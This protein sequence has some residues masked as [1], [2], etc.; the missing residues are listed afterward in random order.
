MWE[1]V[2]PAANLVHS[3]RSGWAAARGGASARH[4]E[5]LGTVGAAQPRRPCSSASLPPT[6]PS[7]H[8]PPTPVPALPYPWATLPRATRASAAALSALRR[9]LSS[10]SLP[11]RALA[12]LSDLAGTPVTLSSEAAGPSLH[13][14]VASET[15]TLRLTGPASATALTPWWVVLEVD[16]ALAVALVARVTKRPP[17]LAVTPGLPSANVIGAFVGIIAAAVRR[18][19]VPVLVSEVGSTFGLETSSP[20]TS[21]AAF[22]VFVDD[23]ATQLRAF[24]PA[25]LLASAPVTF[26]RADLATLG[27]LPLDLPIVA[28]RILAAAADLAAL[29][30]GDAW[31]LGDAWRL[32]R[33]P[34]MGT[35]ISSPLHL[36]SASSTTALLAT[37]EADGRLVLRDGVEELGWSP[38]ETAEET[39]EGARVAEAVGDVPVVVRVEIG[40]AR[41]KA[42][43]WAALAPGDVVGIGSKIGAAVVLRV[44]GMAVAEGELVDLE[45]EIGVRIRKRLSTTP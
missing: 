1:D 5:L 38:M 10:R 23:Q 6:P 43:E 18:A 4:R 32:G 40:S 37:L 35:A 7:V 33:L 20:S 9:T 28:C 11:A 45:G 41:M 12:A 19:G 22:T 21:V 24:F 14:T 17:I 8:S 29:T 16:P 34:L 15:L 3:A 26:S 25:P 27:A 30:E 39:E 42:K 36:C 31:M 44:S 13:T 2:P